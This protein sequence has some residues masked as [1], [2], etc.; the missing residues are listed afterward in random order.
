MWKVYGIDI[1][2]M[3]SVVETTAVR[4]GEAFERGEKKRGEWLVWREIEA[5]FVVRSWGMGIF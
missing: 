1:G 5:Q 2:K 3:M 4:L